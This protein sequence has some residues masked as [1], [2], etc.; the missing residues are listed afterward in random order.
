MK[1]LESTAYF[2]AIPF[3]VAAAFK[4]TD[5]MGWPA[6]VIGAPVWIGSVA[7]LAGVGMKP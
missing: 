3:A 2:L 1:N 7:I 5:W 4:F 6:L